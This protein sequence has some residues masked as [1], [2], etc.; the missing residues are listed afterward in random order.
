MQGAGVAPPTAGVGAVGEGTRGAGPLPMASLADS[1]VGWL[2]GAVAIPTERGRGRQVRFLI[3]G[4]GDLSDRGGRGCGC[5]SG[6]LCRGGV[7]VLTDWDISS[8]LANEGW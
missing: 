1:T 8:F 3:W 2:D 5:V 7:G 6:G 4:E